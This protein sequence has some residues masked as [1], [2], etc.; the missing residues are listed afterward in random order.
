MNT[1]TILLAVC[2]V[3]SKCDFE[4]R[5][6]AVHV[7]SRWGP[8]LGQLF[9]RHASPSSPALAPPGVASA[10]LNQCITGWVAIVSCFKLLFRHIR[11]LLLK[12]RINACQSV[13]RHEVVASVVRVLCATLRMSLSAEGTSS[14][15]S[16]FSH[17][18]V[19]FYFSPHCSTC[20]GSAWHY[21][22][23][24]PNVGRI[25]GRRLLK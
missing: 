17:F 15:F 18:F 23:I 7:S 22:Y 19:Q 5:C 24:I 11:C 20:T 25:I 3:S 8:L 12:I 16:F 10:I 14:L 2:S 6:R 4:T 1:C 9:P 13:R 21:L